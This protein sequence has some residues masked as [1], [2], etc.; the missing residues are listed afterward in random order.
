MVH[1]YTSRRLAFREEL[2]LRYWQFILALTRL[3]AGAKEW[4]Q[5]FNQNRKL[6][7]LAFLV[8][9]LIGLVPLLK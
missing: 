1:L 5:I 9:V 2:K 6:M 8:G 7:A 4:A 3:A